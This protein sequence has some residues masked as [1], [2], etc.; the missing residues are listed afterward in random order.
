MSLDLAVGSFCRARRQVWRNCSRASVLIFLGLPL[1]LP[2]MSFL[3]RCSG[4]GSLRI[5]VFP[6][7]ADTRS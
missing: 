7:Y 2:E 6:F 1:G 4:G 5:G 3:K